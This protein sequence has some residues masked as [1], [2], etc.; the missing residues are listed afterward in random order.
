LKIVGPALAASIFLL[1]SSFPTRAADL[2]FHQGFET[3]W[4]NALNKAQFL[5]SVRSSVDGTSACLPPQSGSVSGFGYTICSNGCGTGNPG[6]AVAVQA[7]SFTGDF[8]AGQFSGPGTASNIVVPI[9]TAVLGSCTLNLSNIVLGYALDYLMQVDGVDGVHT[10]DMLGPAVNIVSYAS[11]NDC[12][13]VLAGL[14]ASYTPQAIEQ[15]EAAAA[16][17]IEP[18]L[19]ADTLDRSICPLSAP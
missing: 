7:N 4:V 8:L 13:P 15:A 17:A 2:V 12:N 11:S 10:A 16:E 14:I 9:N 19:R 1:I 18:G 3:C 5:E 6:C